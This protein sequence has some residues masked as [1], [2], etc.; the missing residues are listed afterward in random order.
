MEMALPA[1]ADHVE[2]AAVILPSTSF[3]DKSRLRHS[4]WKSGHGTQPQSLPSFLEIED[5]SPNIRA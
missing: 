5:I 1:R 3:G 4:R 2:I